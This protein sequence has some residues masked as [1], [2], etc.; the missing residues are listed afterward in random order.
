MNLCYDTDQSIDFIGFHF[1]CH[2]LKV[3]KKQDLYFIFELYSI[4]K[5]LLNEYH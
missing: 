3:M 1:R 4:F 2:N 5:T